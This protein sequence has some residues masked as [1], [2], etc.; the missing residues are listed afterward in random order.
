VVEV[1]QKLHLTQSSEAEHGVIKWSNLLDSDLLAGGLV[2]SG[3]REK[4]H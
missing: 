4:L 2:K 1:S 3:A